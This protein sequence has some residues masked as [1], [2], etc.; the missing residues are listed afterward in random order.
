VYAPHIYTGGFNGGPITTRAFEIAFE[1]AQL[2]GGAPV[3]SGEWG[4]GPER[5]SD[6]ADRYFVEHQDL[7]D[8]F[9]FGA[10]LWTWRESCGDPHKAGDYRAGRI[11]YVWGEFDVD[12]E[13]NEV[14]GMRQDLFDQLTRAYV[15]AAPGQLIEAA[16]SH[17]DKDGADAGSFRARGESAPV[18]SLLVVFY[19]VS[20][21]GTAT[22]ASTGLDGVEI[23]PAAGGNAYI[24]GTAVGGDWSIEISAAG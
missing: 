10:T 3:V 22:T 11:P 19:P 1:E 7:Q 8:R 21:H 9:R 18:G 15:R 13:T 24:L 6:P 5:A 20:R 17:D 16:Y 12:C 14:S 4:A 2:F 23:L